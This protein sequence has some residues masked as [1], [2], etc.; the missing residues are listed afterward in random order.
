MIPACGPQTVLFKIQG[1][2]SS[3]AISGVSGP[4]EGTLRLPWDYRDYL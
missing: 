1:L 4:T 2:R 3:G